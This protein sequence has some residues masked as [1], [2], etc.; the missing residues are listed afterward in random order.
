MATVTSL[1]PRSPSRPRSSLACACVWYF[2][3]EPS[4]VQIEA[5]FCADCLETERQD[6]AIQDEPPD[7]LRYFDHARVGQEFLQVAAHGA[8]RR[9]VRSAEIDQHHGGSGDGAWLEGGFFGERHLGD[10]LL[11]VGAPL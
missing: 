5:Y 9:F 6:Y 11:F 7:C 2:S 3:G 8:W 4:L 10:F 1:W